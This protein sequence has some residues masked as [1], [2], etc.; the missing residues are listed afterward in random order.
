MNIDDEL[1]RTQ[2]PI[3]VAIKKAIEEVMHYYSYRENGE[4]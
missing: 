3:N 4:E 1:C 2:Y